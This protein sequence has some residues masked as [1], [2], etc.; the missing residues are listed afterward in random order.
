[1]VPRF[2]MP[3][4]SVLQMRDVV[5]RTRKKHLGSSRSLQGRKTDEHSVGIS[6]S[7]HGRTTREKG[8]GLASR[9]KENGTPLLL[10]QVPVLQKADL[11]NQ[12]RE[13][14]HPWEFALPRPVES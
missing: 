12:H 14:K 11:Q 13:L 7:S 4:A 2:W 10:A 5:Q 6:L 9:A 3:R 1:M 8:N